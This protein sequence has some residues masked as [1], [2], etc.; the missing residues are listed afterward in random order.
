MNSDKHSKRCEKIHNALCAC[1]ICMH[2]NIGMMDEEKFMFANRFIPFH[3]VTTLKAEEIHIGEYKACMLNPL[4][5]NQTFSTPKFWFH[6]PGRIGPSKWKFVRGPGLGIANT[7]NSCFANAALQALIYC[8]PLAQ[9]FL[10]KS[11]SRKCERRRENIECVC[12]VFEE[13]L[14]RIFRAKRNDGTPSFLK[15]QAVLRHLVGKGQSMLFQHD[16]HEALTALL[17]KLRRCD[18]PIACERD[19]ERHLIPNSELSTSYLNQ[20]L[21][22]FLVESMV[23]LVCSNAS[24]TFQPFWDIIVSIQNCSSLEKALEIY[25]TDEYL[26]PGNEAW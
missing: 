5:N 20:L 12:C 7:G 6:P 15:P 22:G 18:L 3:E 17:E 4:D 10:Q 19:F 23:C 1:V 2:T 26:R 14:N 25:F 8:P 13:F 21:V 9:D 16:T 24:K 11:H